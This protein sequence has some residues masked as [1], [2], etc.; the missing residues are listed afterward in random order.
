MLKES[1][2]MHPPAAVKRSEVASM[3]G[4]H[5]CRAGKN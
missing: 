4:R 1:V 2:E 5:C 3:P